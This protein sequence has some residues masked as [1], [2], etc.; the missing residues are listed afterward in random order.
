MSFQMS[1]SLGVGVPY[2]MFKLLVLGAELLGVD[3]T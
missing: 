1:S 2:L 3:W